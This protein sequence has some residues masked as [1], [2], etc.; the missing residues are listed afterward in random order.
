[1]TLVM[2]GYITVKQLHQDIGLYVDFLFLFC[3]YTQN[4]LQNKLWENKEL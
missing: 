2:T 1:M 3:L 4:M